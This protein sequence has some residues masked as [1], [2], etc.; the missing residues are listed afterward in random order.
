MEARNL[1]VIDLAQMI[2]DLQKATQALTVRI[3]ALSGSGAVGFAA[4]SGAADAG[5]SSGA[6]FAT[7]SGARI[8][9]AVGNPIIQVASPTM[10]PLAPPER[11]FGDPLKFA[12]FVNQCQLQFMCKPMCFPDEQSKVAFVLS[13][14]GGTAATWSI[15]LVE[16]NDPLLYDYA[17]FKATFK[18]LFDRH[19][20]VQSIDS[21]LLNLRQGNTTLMSYVSHFNRLVSEA[22]WPE[23]KRS[24]LFYKGLREELKDMVSQVVNPPDTCNE[25]IDLVVKLDHRLSERRR[26]KGRHESRMLVYRDKRLEPEKG[27]D[28]SEPMQ[29]G[30]IRGPLT[31]E[32]RK[33]RRSLGLCLYC[34]KKG[35]FLRDCL[36]KPK[37]TAE[38]L[39]STT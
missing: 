32:E 3:D 23:E 38:G 13:Y 16:R 26:E 27:L 24:T 19:S 30:S 15:P 34:G 10:I 36:V 6:S 12:S 18:R 33:R 20:Y 4:P 29:I 14:L 21:E 17:S 7:P 22:N 39:N 37:R 11:F 5:L 8:R 25:L 31:E 28:D 35:H 2:G 9:Q 1:T